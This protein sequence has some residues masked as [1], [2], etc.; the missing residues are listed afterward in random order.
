MRVLA[1]HECGIKQL[2]PRTIPHAESG[3]RVQCV[4]CDGTLITNRPGFEDRVLGFSLAGLIMLAMSFVFPFLTLEISGRIQHMTLLSGLETVWQQGYGF[5]AVITGL[6]V[7]VLPAGLLIA[8]AYCVLVYRFT[9]QAPKHTLWLEKVLEWFIGWN[10]ADVFLV[11]VLVS[12]VKLSSLASVVPGLSFVAYIAFSL[13]LIMAM[14]SLDHHQLESWFTD[15]HS[16]ESQ[17]A[18]VNPSI[19]LQRC[20]ALLI[21][22][23]IC[24]IPANLLPITVT[25]VLGKSSPSTIMGG[26]VVLWE[27]GSYPVACVVFFASIFVP[28]AKILSLAFLFIS[29]QRGMDTRQKERIAL[30]RLTEL[31][32]RWSMIDVFVVVMLVSLVQF[33]TLVA[34]YVGPAVYAFLAVVVLT[35]L[36]AESFDPKTIW[37]EADRLQQNQQSS[38]DC[39]NPASAHG[40]VQ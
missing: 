38:K 28:V 40:H 18:P 26:V 37:S 25:T 39:L 9:H 27:M 3:Y 35:M 1:C 19:M 36:A 31:F 11:G 30:Y 33:N 10:M 32:G 16:L 24:F 20:W 5:L 6:M 29:V 13:C 8:L 7:G 34:F 4:R 23:A 2:A 17:K 21:A 15:N 22:A 12:L 14:A